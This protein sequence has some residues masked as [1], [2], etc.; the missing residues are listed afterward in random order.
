MTT[1]VDIG[2]PAYKPSNEPK[3]DTDSFTDLIF[4]EEGHSYSAKI[5]YEYAYYDGA[6]RVYKCDV[7]TAYRHVTQDDIYEVLHLREGKRIE[8]ECTINFV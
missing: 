4:D 7:S 5:D 3:F 1:S 2:N 8:F 6:C